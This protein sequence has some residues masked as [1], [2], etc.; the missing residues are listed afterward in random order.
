MSKILTINDETSGTTTLLATDDALSIA[1]FC[2]AYSHHPLAVSILENIDA[3]WEGGVGWYNEKDYEDGH[4]GG[5]IPTPWGMGKTPFKA[6]NYPVI[7]PLNPVTYYSALDFCTW[8]VEWANSADYFHSKYTNFYSARKAVLDGKEICSTKVRQAFESAPKEFN[9]Y[10]HKYGNLYKKA[11]NYLVKAITGKPKKDKFD[12]FLDGLYDF[13]SVLTGATVGIAAMVATGNP[14]MGAVVFGLTKKAADAFSEQDLY[15]FVDTLAGSAVQFNL[16]PIDVPLPKGIPVSLT[17][18]LK[19]LKKRF[20]EQYPDVV[21]DYQSVAEE[22]RIATGV[23]TTDLKNH[24]LEA[25]GQAIEDKQ[26]ITK[27]NGETLSVDGNDYAD[28][29]GM[30]VT[31]QKMITGADGKTIKVMHVKTPV[32]AGGKVEAGQESIITKQDGTTAKVK[33]V[34]NPNK[35]EPT[36]QVETDNN[37]WMLPAGALAILYFL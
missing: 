32:G 14:F 34:S 31:K 15:G 4:W 11:S 33:I 28:Y 36:N 13:G 35:A 2:T 25:I 8:Y 5:V 29:N 26:Y 10:N 22:I 3:W 21:T 12:K 24:Y 19:K 16:V 9:V 17:N 7:R 27:A 1:Q 37:G 20:N 30:V 18:N 23:N 6:T